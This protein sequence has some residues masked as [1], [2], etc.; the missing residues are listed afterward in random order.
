VD[1]SL[2]G[3]TTYP[4]VLLSSTAAASAPSVPVQSAWATTRA[5]VRVTWIRNSAVTDTSNA[6]FTIR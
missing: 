4:V 5:R 3:G 1:L 2:D 6:N